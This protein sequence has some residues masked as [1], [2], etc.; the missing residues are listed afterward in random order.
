MNIDQTISMDFRSNPDIYKLVTNNNKLTFEKY[1]YNILTRDQIYKNIINRKSVT[2]KIKPSFKNI[3]FKINP[4][5]VKICFDKDIFTLSNKNSPDYYMIIK[6]TP[7]LDFTGLCDLPQIY[8]DEI[9]SNDNPFRRVVIEGDF[10]INNNTTIYVGKKLTPLYSIHY[11]Q[12][13]DEKLKEKALEGYPININNIYID[14]KNNIEIIENTDTGYKYG[15][16]GE[17]N[18]ESL[19]NYLKIHNYYYKNKCD[20]DDL[21]NLF[22]C[23]D[24]KCSNKSDEQETKPKPKQ[25]GLFGWFNRNKEDSNKEDSDEDYSDEEEDNPADKPVE[26]KPVE[27]KPEEDKPKE[28]ESD[29]EDNPEDKPVEDK[30]AIFYE[31]IENYI[32]N[33]IDNGKSNTELQEQINT[34][35][36]E[37][38][39][40][41]I[42]K[43]DYN[44]AKTI[45]E[46]FNLWIKNSCSIIYLHNL[47]ESLNNDKLT[48]LVNENE[49]KIFSFC[50]PVYITLYTDDSNMKNIQD[51][52]GSTCKSIINNIDNLTMRIE[53]SDL[54]EQLNICKDKNKQLENDYQQCNDNFTEQINTVVTQ[55]KE[56]M[57]EKEKLQEE[58]ERLQEENESNKSMLAEAQIRIEELEKALQNNK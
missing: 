17:K 41:I 58:N 45:H 7:C 42:S 36:K 43:Y 50:K 4:N 27:D 54:T 28:E 21:S 13:I 46:K 34:F 51:C 48:Q 52:N 6:Y 47:I 32:Q 57:E 44:D 2:L 29:E 40:K 35:F 10:R 30:I 12:I 38:P 3:T 33:Y 9:N 5:N 22:T 15:M 25:G 37:I 39:E 8:I 53:K 20:Y 24:E 11:N 49:E 23:V 14:S 56:L 55:N 31:K 1:N 19:K 18:E 16:K 26:D